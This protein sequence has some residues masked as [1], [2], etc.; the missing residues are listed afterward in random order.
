MWPFDDPDVAAAASLLFG[1]SD[2]SQ[3]FRSD[4]HAA[5]MANSQVMAN[6]AVQNHLSSLKAR[7]TLTV[8]VIEKPVLLLGYDGD[9]TNHSES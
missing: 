9:L 2:Y 5:Q 1:Y 3:A 8:R 6:A 7:S 4:L